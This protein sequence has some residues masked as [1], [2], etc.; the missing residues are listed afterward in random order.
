MIDLRRLKQLVDAAISME[1]AGLFHYMSP[2]EAEK[3][4]KAYPGVDMI[5]G[6]FLITDSRQLD[7]TP[8]Y[9]WPSKD[10]GVLK[11]DSYGFAKG[12]L[13]KGDYHVIGEGG[14]E[15]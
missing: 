15:S 7:E 3:F 12:T 1:E 5:L 8:Q 13:S 9:A 11:F 14:N 10:S 2:D 6:D 4:R